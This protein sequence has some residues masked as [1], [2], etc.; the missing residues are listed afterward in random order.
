MAAH[1]VGPELPCSLVLDIPFPNSRLASIAL[2]A[3]G[4]DKELSALVRRELS[5]AAPADTP[6]AAAALDSET[7]LRVRY[8]ASTNRMLR[9]AVN[10][11]LESLALVLEVMGELDVDV[12]EAQRGKTA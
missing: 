8:C 2:Q 4:V 12:L 6:S 9:V 7:V 3:L 1:S 10:S 5:T 11:F